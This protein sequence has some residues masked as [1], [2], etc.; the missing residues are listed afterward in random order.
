MY[1]L[2]PHPQGSDP[3]FAWRRD[4]IGGSD[5]PAILGENPWKSR[6][7]LL[8][9]KVGTPRDFSS[10][11]MARGTALEPVARER[12]I[13]TT[14]IQLAPAC[15]QSTAYAWL[16]ASLDGLAADGGAVVEIKCGERVHDHTGR[17]GMVPRYYV[18][19]LQHI[20]AATGLP[21]I[22][23][24]CHWPGRDD[25]LVRVARDDTYIARLLEAEAAFW[26]EVEALRAASR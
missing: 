9:E 22:D 24:F 12:Y 13:A 21:H 25:V 6:R 10:A 26:A 23:F 16:R 7:R 20:L 17:T 14:G 4:G 2:I 18:G 15:V 5:A 3:W 11:A 19:Q 1:H 8:A